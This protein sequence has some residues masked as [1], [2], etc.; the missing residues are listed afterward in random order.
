MAASA[1]IFKIRFPEFGDDTLYPEPR[2]QLFLDDAANCYMGT[3]ETRW[4]G[5]YDYAQVY[6]AAHLLTVGTTSETGSA[7][8]TVGAI[9]SKSVD[10]VSISRDVVSKPRSDEDAWL[11]S[12]TYGQQFVNIR[13]SCIASVMVVC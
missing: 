12:T 5:K 8:S 6:L 1:A 13:N 2:V 4:C 3:D 7:S 9:S 10:G 11:M